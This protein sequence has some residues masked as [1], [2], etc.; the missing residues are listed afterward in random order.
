MAFQILEGDQAVLLIGGVYKQCDLYTFNGGLFAKTSGGFVRLKGDGST[1]KPN[2]SLK[3]LET[4][5]SLW[6]DPFGR[7]CS[8]GG[9]KRKPV[10]LEFKE[11]ETVKVTSVAQ[12][13]E[14]LL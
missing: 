8:A 3:H 13:R 4:E 7:L 5:I 6:S 12:D 1:S 11:D 9:G 10:A 14:A 2:M